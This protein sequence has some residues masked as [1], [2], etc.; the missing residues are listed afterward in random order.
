MLLR[1]LRYPYSN[2]R[3]RALA[4]GFLKRE[5]VSEMASLPSREQ[6]ARSLEPYFSV[7]EGDWSVIEWRVR[8]EFQ[9]LGAKVAQALPG[10]GRRLLE[11]YLRR[12]E[13]ENLKIACRGLLQGKKI[14]E[15]QHLFIPG[16]A[17]GGI[18]VERL[19][20]VQTLEDLIPVLRRRS[21]ARALRH[22]L[23]AA[24]EKRLLSIE[25]A[26]DRAAWDDIAE[27]LLDLNP[28]DRAEAAE[29]LNLRA[30]LERFNVVHRGWRGG[31]GE[32]ELLNALPP[33]GTAYPAN[34][35]RQALRSDDPE[36]GLKRI[37][38]LSAGDNPL[39]AAGEVALLRRL[40]RELLKTMR[41]HPFDLAIPLATVL[42]KELES[43]DVQAI[44]S[45]LRLGRP[46]EDI[47]ALLATAGE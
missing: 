17:A 15:F 26:L 43:R 24:E 14:E 33:L 12:S 30:D 29:L 4:A 23:E 45:G 32:R 8:A 11:A 25:L 41:S 19:R 34:R 35:V 31:L 22:G 38:P 27:S 10:A 9:S 16:A 6:V 13:A 28:G 40:F 1:L 7:P 47:A 3:S 2:A 44:L 20:Q 18:S 5:G 37:F 39:S 42:L 46:R 36:A 21:Y